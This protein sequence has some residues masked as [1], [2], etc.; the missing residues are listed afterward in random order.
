MLSYAYILSG[1]LFDVGEYEMK[2]GTQES[3]KGVDQG[4]R[5]LCEG[6][7][8]ALRIH[9]DL[10]YGSEGLGNR[11]PADSEVIYDVKVVRIERENQE[12]KGIKMEEYYRLKRLFDLIRFTIK[13]C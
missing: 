10:A 7:E 3:I 11:V 6:D 12:R 4:L 1:K 5:G 8:R 2:I 13:S 9:P